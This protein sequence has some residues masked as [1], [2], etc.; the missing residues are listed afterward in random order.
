MKFLN[1]FF[2]VYNFYK[3]DFEII[4]S[5]FDGNTIEDNYS[6]EGGKVQ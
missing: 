4:F 1:K 3:K 6:N 2:T 5:D